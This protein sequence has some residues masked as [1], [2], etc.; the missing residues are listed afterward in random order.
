MTAVAGGLVLGSFA[1]AEK[2]RLAG[3]GGIGDGG[4][5][6]AL[7]RSV[8][9][10]LRLAFAAG[11]PVVRLTFFNVYGDGFCSGYDG[12]AHGM[13]PVPESNRVMAPTLVKVPE[14]LKPCLGQ[15]GS[16]GVGRG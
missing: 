9:K 13:G 6:R 15:Q 12:F 10:R 4:E 1:G 5:V 16:I 3:F 14:D 8:A 2:D 11:A 7:V